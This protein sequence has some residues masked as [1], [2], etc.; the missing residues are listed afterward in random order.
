[1]S[2]H[3]WTLQILDD[4]LLCM[5]QRLMTA[6]LLH[7]DKVDWPDIFFF[8]SLQSEVVRER[9][10]QHRGICLTI[11]RTSPIL[12]LAM[13]HY[14]E[15]LRRQEM[16]ISFAMPPMRFNMRERSK[17]GNVSCTAPSS[18]ADIMCRR[19]ATESCRFRNGG[20]MMKP[21]WS[22]QNGCGR[23]S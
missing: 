12:L 4:F 23:M 19:R 5:Q 22:Y 3:T 8:R 9:P 6:V 10:L 2:N 1:M 21:I 17:A 16:S 13:R 20:Q 7:A 18:L 11:V 15:H 14:L